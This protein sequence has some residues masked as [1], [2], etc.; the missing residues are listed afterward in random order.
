MLDP[1]VAK[2][3]GELEEAKRANPPTDF[4]IPVEF[5]VAVFRFGHSMVRDIYKSIND[6]KSKVEL[7]AILGLT[8]PMGLTPPGGR[9]NTALPAEWVI[10]WEHFFLTPL[11]P[12]VVNRARKIDTQIAIQL[13][14]LDEPT[15][16]SFN[17]PVPGELPEPHLPVRT[18]LRGFR[19]DLPSGEDVAGEIARRVPGVKVLTEDEVVSGCHKDIL[20]DPKYGFRN[21]T[22]L[23]YYI[24]KEAE[25]IH[26]GR[27]LGPIGSLHR[28]RCDHRRLG[29]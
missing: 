10:S 25:V 5:N 24:L 17:V 16:K 28:R 6:H 3:L 2:G 26:K 22:P 4:R 12:G 18:L 21:N 11:R 9:G 19:V 23:W 1:Q 13:H 14:H 20:T 15:I 7:S 27:H 29:R 8:G